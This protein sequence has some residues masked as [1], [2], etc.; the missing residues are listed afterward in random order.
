M[1]AHVPGIDRV[2]AEGRI[3]DPEHRREVSE[4]GLRGAVAAPALVRLDGG[5]G[6]DVD[7]PRSLPEARQRELDE[8]ERRDHVH[9]VHVPQR[10]EP[11]VAERR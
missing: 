2:G 5:V 8:G 9:L 1:R 11:V 4:R 3:L 7:D 6:A 10:L